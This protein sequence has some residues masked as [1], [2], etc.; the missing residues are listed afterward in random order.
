M[1]PNI[2]QQKLQF[3]HQIQNVV[4]VV[5]MQG[6]GEEGKTIKQQKIYDNEKQK[7]EGQEEIQ[8]GS[9]HDDINHNDT[10]INEED[11]NDINYSGNGKNILDTNRCQNRIWCAHLRG[12]KY[13]RKSAK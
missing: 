5:D 6:Y 12:A 11:G 2:Y 8:Q 9:C 3:H 13:A 4:V 10:I 7:H 1:Y